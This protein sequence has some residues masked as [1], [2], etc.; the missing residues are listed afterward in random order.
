MANLPGILARVDDGERG[1][2]RITGTDVD[3]I[4]A[5]SGPGWNWL[6]DFGGYPSWNKLAWYGVE[7][8][9]METKHESG[10]FASQADMDAAGLCS[11]LSADGLTLM[12]ESQDIWRMPTVDEM[13]ASLA[14]HGENCGCEWL[15]G[16]Q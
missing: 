2:R 4:W 3:L 12:D 7:P 11:Y 10:V 8:V 6:Q 1:M 14:L 15:G 13:V 16:N 5:P 9:G